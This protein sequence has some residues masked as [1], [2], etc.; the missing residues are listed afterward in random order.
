M[1]FGNLRWGM[2]LVLV[3]Q[4]L[5]EAAVQRLEK[6]GKSTMLVP[7]AI[8]ERQHPAEQFEEFYRKLQGSIQQQ[9]DPR[10]GRTAAR[11]VPGVNGT[12]TKGGKKAGP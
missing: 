11:V 4:H 6:G 5:L 8:L 1:R 7:I 2:T 10:D 12:E 3:R 9:E